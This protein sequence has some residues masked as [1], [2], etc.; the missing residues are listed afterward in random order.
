MELSSS[1]G[2]SALN[3]TAMHSSGLSMG[4]AIHLPSY[5]GHR[6]AYS[7]SLTCNSG[8]SSSGRRAKIFRGVHQPRS[9]TILASASTSDGVIS[10]SPQAAALVDS[11]LSLVSKYL[12]LQCASCTRSTNIKKRT[13]KRSWCVCVFVYLGFLIRHMHTNTYIQ[14]IYAYMYIYMYMIGGRE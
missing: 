12:D 9:S 10:T 11:L 3:P 2:S 6:H 14:Y 4:R 8:S 13:Y 7:V 5:P 1:R